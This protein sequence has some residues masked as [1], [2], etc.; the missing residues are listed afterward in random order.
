METVLKKWGNSLAVRIPW[1]VARDLNLED[2]T[3]VELSRHEDGILIE[4][5]NRA[6]LLKLV[7]GDF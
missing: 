3:E 4:V 2:G 1:S 6:R 5:G 7:G